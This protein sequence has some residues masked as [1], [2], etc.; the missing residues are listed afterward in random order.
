[1]TAQISDTIIYPALATDGEETSERSW[2]IAGTAGGSLFDPASHRLK[3]QSAHTSCWRGYHCGYLVIEGELRLAR[4]T[5][6]LRRD[7]IRRI[8]IGAGPKLFGTSLRPRF[9][10][11]QAF[12]PKT[13][14][15]GPKEMTPAG[16]YQVEGLSAPVDFTGGLLLGCDFI[17][18]LY[19][20]LGFQPAYRY[21]RVT[22]LTFER[23]RLQNAEDHS[24]AM[25]RYRNK[26]SQ[27]AERPARPWYLRLFR[28]VPED[29]LPPLPFAHRY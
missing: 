13:G 15:L 16:D 29:V 6:G 7:D 18:E 19:V 11:T 25:A 14:R 23:G 5:C 9:H 28:P 24:D 17:Q 22:E 2:A 27:W 10:L 8:G 4:V 12:D 21:R 3:V 20:H 26:L 1:M